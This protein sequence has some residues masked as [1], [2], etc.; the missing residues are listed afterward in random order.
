VFEKVR[1]K[2]VVVIRNDC[3]N[4]GLTH[5]ECIHDDFVGMFLESFV[6]GLLEVVEVVGD[7]IG[8]DLKS[9]TLDRE[10]AGVDPVPL[11]LDGLRNSKE[12]SL[13]IARLPT[14][15]FCHELVCI[16]QIDIAKEQRR[17]VDL[18][19]E[20]RVEVDVNHRGGFVFQDR[21]EFGKDRSEALSVIK[22]CL[23]RLEGLAQII[24]SYKT[25]FKTIAGLSPIGGEDFEWPPI[26]GGHE[27]VVSVLV[28]EITLQTREMLL[29][30][31]AHSVVR[32]VAP[33]VKRDVNQRFK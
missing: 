30:H 15:R 31:R 23:A 22:P 19:R 16:D 28:N 10:H 20:H 4:V 6:D 9:S 14:L 2:V 3:D 1:E 29:H 24:C 12:F 7:L 18:S 8:E 5:C 11:W 13:R 33:A 27:D 32:R 26:V 21:K 17:Q 25:Q